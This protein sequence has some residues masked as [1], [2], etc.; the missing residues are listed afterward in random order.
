MKRQIARKLSSLLSN[1]IKRIKRK[2]RE[3][4]RKK[5]SKKKRERERERESTE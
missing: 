5:E 1:K 3:L 2:G 4:E